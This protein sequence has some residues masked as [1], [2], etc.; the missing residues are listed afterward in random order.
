MVK[1][2]NDWDALLANEFAADYYLQLRAFLKE[3]YRTR[4]IYPHMNNIFTALKLTPLCGVKAV[5]VGQ[6]PYHRPNEAHGLSFSVQR[7]V[8]I[9]PSLHNIYKELADDIGFAPPAHGYLEAWATRGV[10][11]LNNVLTVE[12]GQARSHANKGWERFTDAVLRHVNQRATPAVFLLWGN[13][14]QK[15]G[16]I[17]TAPQHLVLKAAHPSPLAGGR[18]FGCK[19]FSKA[20]T[21]LEEKGIAPIDWGLE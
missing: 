21:F 7:G 19:H 6:D 8:R 3:G 5:I 18:F 2:G 12:A 13:D 11:M 17:I 16:E 1:L 4:T 9:P 20:N 14:A 10:L 15:K